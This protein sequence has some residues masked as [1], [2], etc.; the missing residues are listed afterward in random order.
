VNC[1]FFSS[2]QY[3][4]LI[5]GQLLALTILLVLQTTLTKPQ[6][7][8]LLHNNLNRIITAGLETAAM[9]GLQPAQINALYFTNNSTGLKGLTDALAAAF[10]T[11]RPVYGERLA[12]VATGLGLYA[13]RLFGG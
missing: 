1:G 8:T 4:T 10:P 5:L 11:A 12:S 6:T 3:V 13:R 2:F 7:T 9:A